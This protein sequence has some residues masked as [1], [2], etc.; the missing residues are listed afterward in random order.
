MQHSFLLF[1]FFLISNITYIYPFQDICQEFID[2]ELKEQAPCSQ[3]DSDYDPL[4]SNRE[5]TE[6]V[7]QASQELEDEQKNTK[8]LP[9]ESDYDPLESNR[10]WTEIVRQAS[11]ELKNQESQNNDYEEDDVSSYKIIHSKFTHPTKPLIIKPDYIPLDDIIN[12]D[13]TAD[14]QAVSEPHPIAE[15]IV[16]SG[17]AGIGAVSLYKAFETFL[18]SQ[19]STSD[20][21]S[22]G[23]KIVLGALAF[24]IGYNLLTNPQNKQ[25]L[26]NLLKKIPGLKRLVH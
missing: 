2:L 20:A 15:I 8:A 14:E 10:E 26:I 11:E 16:G 17:L 24:R 21:L 18:K 3:D 4:E 13:N 12:P 6:I 5:W 9:V 19:V 7:R 25:E 23:V 1:L 22:F